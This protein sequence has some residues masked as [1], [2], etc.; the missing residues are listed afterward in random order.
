MIYTNCMSYTI[1][2]FR[3]RNFTVRVTAEEECD[4]DLSWDDTGEVA[5]K[6]ARGLYTV[7]C[8][9]CAIYYRGRAIAT[10]YLGNCIYESPDDFRDHVG[11]AIQSRT[12]GRDYGSYF[13]DMVRAAVREARQYIGD[14]RRLRV[15]RV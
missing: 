2:Q 13:A 10:E 8:A 4:V 14:V 3:T 6:I 1:W 7:F 11:L 15:A 9:K 5:D 12:D